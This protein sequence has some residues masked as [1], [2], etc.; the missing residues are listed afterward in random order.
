M[1]RLDR[2]IDGLAEHKAT[3]ETASERVSSPVRVHD[4]LVLERGDG[5]DL[6]V[7]RVGRGHD[8]RRLRA[9]GDDD[10]AR[11]GGVRFWLGGDR[12]RDGGQVFAV[13]DAV[14]AA[15]RLGLGFVSDD[16]VDVGEDLLELHGEELRYEGRGEVEDEDLHGARIG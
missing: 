15:P 12:A 3:E 16:N 2:L 13:G 8:R 10:R 5:V 14:R 6:W 11:A 7:F 4:L 9:V 1:A